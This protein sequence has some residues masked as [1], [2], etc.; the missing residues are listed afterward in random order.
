MDYC[1]TALSKLIDP[2]S[3][4]LKTLSIHQ[5][6][7]DTNRCTPKA[8]C[9]LLFNSS[10]LQELRIYLKNPG[11]LSLLE[12]NTRL[13]RFHFECEWT[14]EHAE[15]IAHVLQKNTTLQHLSLGV[16]HEKQMDLL[17]VITNEMKKNTILK[18]LE[19]VF[20]EDIEPKEYPKFS[21]DSRTCIISTKSRSFIGNNQL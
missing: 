13:I 6:H 19:L 12:S 3:G 21:S 4:K 11:L 5:N 16:F 18:K 8:L 15:S 10:S 7:I 9:I 1:V 14:K 2:S 20:Y 17:V